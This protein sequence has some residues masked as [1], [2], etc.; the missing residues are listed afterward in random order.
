MLENY[1]RHPYQKV[2]V[3]PVARVLCTHKSITPTTITLLGALAGLATIP[4]LYTGQTMMAI[5]LILFS[6]YLDTVDGTLAR[7]TKTTSSVGCV[8]DITCDRLVEFA[9]VLGLFLVAPYDRGFLSLIM[10]GAI[11][12]C[13][14]SFLVVGIFSDN[15]TEKSFHYSP[16][17]MERA[18]AFI[19]FIMMIVFPDFFDPLALTFSVLVF[20]TGFYRIWQFIKQSA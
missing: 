12:F 20:W 3:D 18:E 8:L 1:I 16:G 19:F 9:I 14:T 4:L 6:G 5:L 7:L 10:L 17:L 2:L 15:D 11:L 13:V